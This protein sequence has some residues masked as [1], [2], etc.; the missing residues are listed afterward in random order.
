VFW[1]AVFLSFQLA[2]VNWRK[3]LLMFVLITF[4]GQFADHITKM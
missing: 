4:K 2:Q 1:T 3:L